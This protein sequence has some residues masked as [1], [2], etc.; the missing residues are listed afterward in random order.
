MEVVLHHRRLEGRLVQDPA[1]D[2]LALVHPRHDGAQEGVVEDE[3]DVLDRIRPRLV[4]EV[5]GPRT[6]VA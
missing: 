3:A 4:D 5:A 2:V 6:C 1:E